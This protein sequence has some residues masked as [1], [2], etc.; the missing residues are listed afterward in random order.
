MYKDLPMTKLSICEI[1]AELFCGVDG[2]IIKCLV[3]ITDIFFFIKI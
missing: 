1:G 3:I 2:Q